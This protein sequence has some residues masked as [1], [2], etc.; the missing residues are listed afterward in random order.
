MHLNL[1]EIN[2][3][4]SAEMKFIKME[5]EVLRAIAGALLLGGAGFLYFRL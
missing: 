5:L 1:G 3:E 4:A 2:L